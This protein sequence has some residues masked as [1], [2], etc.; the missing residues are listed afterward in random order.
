MVLMNPGIITTGVPPITQYLFWPVPRAMAKTFGSRDFRA[1][2]LKRS[3]I[4]Q[5]I[6][7]EQVMAD[8][9]LAPRSE[10]YLAG[11]T[12]MMGQYET[13]EEPVMASKVRVPTLI[14]WGMQDRSKRPGEFEEVHRLIPGSTLVEINNSG[15]YVQ[16]EQ[17]AAVAAAMIAE[18]P[19][20]L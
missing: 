10:G 2:F 19:N 1:N 9:M 17:P 5:G 14:T 11:T 15:H 12:S 16:E 4:N 3:F 6:V 20:W 13:G 18:A 7:T 8:M